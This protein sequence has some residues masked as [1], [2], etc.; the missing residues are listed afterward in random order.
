MKDDQTNE[1]NKYKEDFN[2][3]VKHMNDVNIY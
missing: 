2:Q 3:K 1:T